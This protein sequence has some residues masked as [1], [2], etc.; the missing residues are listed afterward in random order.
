MFQIEKVSGSEFGFKLSVLYS[1]P[2]RSVFVF[3]SGL[4]CGKKWHPNTIS[5]V[6]D[7]NPSLART[8]SPSATAMQKLTSLSPNAPKKWNL[9]IPEYPIGWRVL[10]MQLAQDFMIAWE[11]WACFYPMRNGVQQAHNTTDQSSALGFYPGLNHPDQATSFLYS[12]CRSPMHDGA[13]PVAGRGRPVLLLPMPHAPMPLAGFPADMIQAFSGTGTDTGTKPHSE[14]CI[15]KSKRVLLACMLLLR[16]WFR[17]GTVNAWPRVTQHR[18]VLWH[19]LSTIF[20]CFGMQ[21][22]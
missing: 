20:F 14:P 4:K 18:L 12:S 21:A 22:I 15:N 8:I 17:V 2:M 7:L 5:S 3:V 1:Y 6:S 10:F 11:Q 16:I 9:S 19:M 13:G